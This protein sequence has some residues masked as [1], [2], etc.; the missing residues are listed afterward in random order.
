M[1]RT[2]S[3]F[4]L[5]LGQHTVLKHLL[6]PDGGLFHLPTMVRDARDFGC[7]TLDHCISERFVVEIRCTYEGPCPRDLRVL[8]PVTVAC[9]TKVQSRPR[10]K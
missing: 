8:R 1:L 3:A 4:R 6:R 2:I 10:T 5:D 7:V 9:I